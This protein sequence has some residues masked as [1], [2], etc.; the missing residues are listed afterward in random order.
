MRGLPALGGRLPALRGGH[1]AVCPSLAPPS[2][3]A[4]PFASQPARCVKRRRGTTVLQRPQ[5]RCTTRTVAA[6]DAAEAERRPSPLPVQALRLAVTLR[7]LTR[8]TQ[9]GLLTSGMASIGLTYERKEVAR[10]CGGRGVTEGVGR[11]SGVAWGWVI[12]ATR[13]LAGKAKQGAR[14]ARV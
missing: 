10:R 9:R 7:R 8:L 14:L 2:S 3:V 4:L 12:G 1:L 13:A 5:R 6:T 11:H